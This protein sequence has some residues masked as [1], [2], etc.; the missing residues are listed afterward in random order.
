[1]FLEGQGDTS[2]TQQASINAQHN[3]VFWYPIETAS[4]QL[5]YYGDRCL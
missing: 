4:K 1:M 2:L 3:T 5:H